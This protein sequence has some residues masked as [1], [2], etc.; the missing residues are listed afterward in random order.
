MASDARTAVVQVGAIGPVPQATTTY[1]PG[2]G[3]VQATVATGKPAPVQKPKQAASHTVRRGET[4]TQVAG[5]Y[6]CDMRVLA[7]ANGIKPPR[8]MVQPGQKLKL[9]GCRDL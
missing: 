1:V 2:Q 6:Q 4:L 3:A 8:Y 7:Q 5:K 9:E